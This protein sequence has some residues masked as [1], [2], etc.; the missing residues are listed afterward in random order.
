M[1]IHY[2]TLA[3]IHIRLYAYIHIV[4]FITLAD[5]DASNFEGQRNPFVITCDDSDEERTEDSSS[6]K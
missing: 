4:L 2:I 3:Y 1:S 5:Y 6:S